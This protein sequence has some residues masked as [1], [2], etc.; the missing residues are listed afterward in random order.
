MKITF[1]HNP[2]YFQ[3][4][5]ENVSFT[6][7]NFGVLPPL[8]M[9]Y[10][11]ALLKEEG[12]ET[13]IVDVKAEG[14]SEQEVKQKIEDF[15]PD[16]IG[17]MVIPY[18]GG[19]AMEWAERMDEWFDVPIVAGNYGVQ[20]YP[21]AVLSNDFID[22]INIGSA[23]NTLSKLLEYIDGNRESIEGVEGLGYKTDDGEMFIN[24]REKRTE[25]FDRLPWPDR[26]AI[27]NSNYTSMLARKRP[28]TLVV[29]SYGCIYNCDFCDMGS[30]GYSERTP[31]DVVDEIEYCVEEYGVKEID[32]FDRDFL[33]KK[34]K[35]REICKEMIDRDI[36]VDWSCRARVD[37]VN[38]GLLELMSDAGC[39]AIL[40]GIESG[41]QRILDTEHKGITLEEIRK[42]LRMTKDAGIDT[43]GFFIIGHEGETEE[44]I[45]QTIEMSK[46]LPIDYAQFFRM[47]G[48]PGAS[49]YDQ[50]T[51]E[52]GYDYF[53][54]LIRGE[55]VVR[56]L[57][58]PWTKF[59]NDELEEFVLEA[60]REFYL[61]PEF[62]IGELR[63]ARSF[64]RLME[65][66]KVGAEFIYDNI[67]H[68][69][70][71]LGGG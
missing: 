39:R 34:E 8:G 30:F 25:D 63:R 57:P 15:D 28:F 66:S 44:T 1:L 68:F 4:Y 19:I 65:I 46:E 16:V 64:R 18:T 61:R 41:D 7:N 52:L 32:I 62:I 3:E 58:R 40:Y 70:K 50:I 23:R 17:V 33:I 67:R 71:E 55:E 49:L 6:A 60:Y 56:D 31:E 42:G 29:T 51:D 54:K 37:E 13:Q 12:Y 43:L 10:A 24:D 14:L 36:E 5:M 53:E 35:A 45:R 20:L 21:E 22:Y 2:Y 69:L 27:D 9:M 11:S 26:D 47:S 38:E 59:S 48:K